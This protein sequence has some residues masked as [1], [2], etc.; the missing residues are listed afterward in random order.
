MH[1]RNAMNNAMNIYIVYT[2]T[3]SYFVV[4]L[5]P[6]Q[7]KICPQPAGWGLSA[8]QPAAGG[9]L[10]GSP[11]QSMPAAGGGLFGSP[12]QSVQGGMFG[13][14]QP[15]AR[16]GVFG[17]AQQPAAEGGT[18]AQPLHTACEKGLLNEVLPL[19]EMRASLEVKDE[20]SGWVSGRMHR[21]K[22]MRREPGV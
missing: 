18:T 21:V 14:A 4:N 9:G 20:A 19:I 12:A 16:G 17:A 6:S 7:H 13:A 2:C 11:A 3:T 22:V 10:F 1:M 5:L 8:A 15:A